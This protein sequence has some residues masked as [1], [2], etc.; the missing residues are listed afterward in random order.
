MPQDFRRRVT[1]PSCGDLHRTGGPWRLGMG[2]RLPDRGGIQA[3]VCSKG[4]GPWD[5]R[6]IST[7]PTVVLRKWNE[8]YGMDFWN[9]PVT[10]V[11]KPTVIQMEFCRSQVQVDGETE[12]RGVVL[13]VQVGCRLSREEDARQWESMCQQ[14]EQRDE[15]EPPKSSTLLHCQHKLWKPIC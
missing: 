1:P 9:P 2:I 13:A 6:D 3:S 15:C 12:E 11:V 5:F 14:A 10:I 7:H 4:C 8:I